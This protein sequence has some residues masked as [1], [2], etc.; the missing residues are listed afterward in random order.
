MM[1]LFIISGWMGIAVLLYSPP[2]LR[3]DETLKQLNI[4][5][6]SLS[7][8]TAC[9]RV[10]QFAE[11]GYQYLDFDH[12][13]VVLPDWVHQSLEDIP[14]NIPSHRTVSKIGAKRDVN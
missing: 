11:A 5:A 10:E 3:Q 2:L 8:M 4:S 7:E 9:D 6:I 12:L 1:V 13:R 14:K